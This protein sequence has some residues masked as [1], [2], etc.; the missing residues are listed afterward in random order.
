MDVAFHIQDCNAFVNPWPAQVSKLNL[1]FW[2]LTDTLKVRRTAETSLL[3]IH[4][5][6]RVEDNIHT[7]FSNLLIER[8]DLWVIGIP[9]GRNHLDS[10]QTEF[11]V[12]A[13]HFFDHEINGLFERT[14]CQLRNRIQYTETK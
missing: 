13:P 2:N 12:T 1:Q 11:V 8:H 10:T 7:K 4:E 6:T 5:D 9:M 3:P 14:T